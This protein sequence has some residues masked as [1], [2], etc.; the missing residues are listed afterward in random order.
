M[1]DATVATTPTTAAAAAHTSADR[2]A[3]VTV[4]NSAV[5]R[6]PTRTADAP[7]ASA[8][9]VTSRTTS[10]TTH[11]AE[12]TIN[13]RA[14]EHV[15]DKPGDF[16]IELALRPGESVAKVELASP[17]SVDI[18]ERAV[19]YKVVKRSLRLDSLAFRA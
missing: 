10:A 18:G 4:A 16:S 8:A 3:T 7:A 15:L 5:V 17:Q 19:R 14:T 12:A 11:T 13:G 1:R 9:E 2:P 6:T